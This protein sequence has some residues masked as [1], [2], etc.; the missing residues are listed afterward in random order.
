MIIKENC[1]LLV[2]KLKLKQEK[3]LLVNKEQVG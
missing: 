3:N 2:L 1:I